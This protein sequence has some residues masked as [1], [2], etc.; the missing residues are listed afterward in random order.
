LKFFRRARP[1]VY[2]M[3]TSP[4]LGPNDPMLTNLQAVRSFL[5]VV[6]EGEV[7]AAAVRLHYSPSTVR[8]HVRLLEQ[9]LHVRLLDR[10]DSSV[11][12]TAA[13]EALV[14]AVAR[15][16]QAIAQLEQQAAR[17]ADGATPRKRTSKIRSPHSKYR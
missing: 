11:L 7:R 8:A 14:P 4:V 6:Q 3:R 5:A 9:E 17:I 12:L 10:E 16:G 13:G 15:V 2:L 1:A